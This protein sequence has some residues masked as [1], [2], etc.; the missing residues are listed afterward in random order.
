MVNF[1]FIHSYSNLILI[2]GNE[3]NLNMVAMALSGF[4]DDRKTMWRDMCSSLSGQLVNPYLRA[5]F[6]F[7][8]K[9]TDQYN[10]ILVS[11]K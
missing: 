3:S 10:D 8:T 4:S 9:D 7:L 2:A 6:A 1:T 5:L 11:E